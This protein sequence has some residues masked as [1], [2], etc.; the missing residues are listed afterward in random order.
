[1]CRTMNELEKVIADYRSL[2]A[3]KEQLEE[4]LKAVEREI[5]G[6]MD[7]NEKMTETGNDFTVKLST[8]ERRTLDSKRLEADLGS[9]SE[10]QRISQYRRLYVK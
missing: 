7:A 9:L 6:Y 10:Y 5:I 8:C 1:M 4:E 2:K 3:M